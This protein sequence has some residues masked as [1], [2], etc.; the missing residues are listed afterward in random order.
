MLGTPAYDHKQE[1]IE[2][3]ARSRSAMLRG[4]EKL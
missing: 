3:N 4:C 1:E 2:I